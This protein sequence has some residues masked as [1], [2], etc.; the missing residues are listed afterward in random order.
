MVELALREPI[1]QGKSEGDQL[2]SIFRVLGSPTVEQYEEFSK[3]VPFDP[4]IFN[5]FKT[6]PRPDISAKFKATIQDMDNFLD[7][8][9]KMFEY[10]P[11]KRITTEEALKHPFFR[12]VRDKMDL[13]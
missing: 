11:S 6:Y 12:D 10:I 2:F 8:M 5:D 3:M 9:Y 4:K 1:F 7:L 13:E